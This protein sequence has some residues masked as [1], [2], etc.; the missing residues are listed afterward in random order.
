MTTN[1]QKQNELSFSTIL[2]TMNKKL[3]VLAGYPGVGK[4]FVAQEIASQTNAE[5]HQTDKIRKELF[6]NPTYSKQE[7]EKTY[8]ELFSRAEQTLK[9]NKTA[10]LDATFN[11]TIGREN[12][13]QIANKQNSEIIFINVI[14][15]EQTVKERINNRDG[16]SDADFTVYQK[17]RD[18]FEPF[19][20]QIETINNSKTKSHTKNQ[21]T[22]LLQK[23]D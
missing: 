2:V 5:I 8:S 9:E 18:A 12:A 16:I 4:S 3:I 20:R 1:T 19:K 21:I 17:V 13:E 6:T 11:L 15:D 22:T 23:Y 7:S 10:I 14:C